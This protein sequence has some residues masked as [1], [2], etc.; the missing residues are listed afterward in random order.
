MNCRVI[1][2]S[3]HRTPFFVRWPG[4]VKAGTTTDQLT[5][6]TDVMATCAEIVGA[7]LVV[8]LVENLVGARPKRSRTQKRSNSLNFVATKGRK[9]VIPYPLYRHNLFGW[10]LST[11]SHYSYARRG[12]P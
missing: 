10:G 3:W 7:N 8:N 6:L 4:K 2:K 11:I 5:S 9:C 1:G 12:L